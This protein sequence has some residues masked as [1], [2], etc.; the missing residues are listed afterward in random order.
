M[1]GQVNLGISVSNAAALHAIV[2]GRPNIAMMYLAGPPGPPG[3][4]NAVYPVLYDIGT[5]TISL[6]M[7]YFSGMSGNL[8]DEIYQTGSYLYGITTGASGYLIS[9]INASSAGVSSINGLSGVLN[10]G[11]A[12]NIFVTTAGQTIIVSGDTG[13]YANFATVDQLTQTGVALDNE[14]NA[15]SGF[16]TGVSGY[17]QNQINTLSGA[18]G[19]YSTGS[20]LYQLI[21][22]LSGQINSDLNSVSGGL[23]SEIDGLQTGLYQTGSDLYALTT[24]SSG[25]LLGLI[26]SI[27]AGV[28][29]VNNLSG[30]INITGAGNVS[31][32]QNGQNII[33]SGDT[34]A[35]ADF[36]TTAQL[37][38]TGA[39]LGNQINS[40]SGFVT[41]ISGSIQDQINALS[42]ATGLYATGS[43][44]YQLVTGLS[45]QVNSSIN[46]VSGGL[47]SEIGSLQT[48]LYQTGSNL[49]ALTTGSSG[50]LLSLISSSSAGVSSLNSLS[51]TI[52]VVGSGNVSVSTNGQIIVVSGDT[53]AYAD[54]ATVSQ[55]TQ[56]GINLQNSTNSLSGFVT[57]ISGSL[58]NQI[59]TLSG[60]TGLYSTGSSLYQL[61]TGLSGSVDEKF[62]QTGSVIIGQINSL[63]G[64][65][66]GVSGYLQSQINNL[67][68]ATGLYSTG[69]S[70][71]NLITG[72]SG[73]QNTNLSEASGVLHDQ[74]EQTGSYLYDTT[75]GASGYLLGLINASS[76]G[77]SSIN[78]LSG[79]LNIAGAG[80]VSVT[81]N[82]QTITVSGDT[83]AYINFATTSQLTQTGSTIDSKINSLS[84]F[85][86]GISG[87]LQDQINALSGATGLYST[88]SNLYQII[89]GLSGSVDNKF[90]ETG[91]ALGAQINSLSG[92]TTGISGYLQNQIASVSGRVIYIDGLSGIVSITGTGNVSVLINGQTIIVSGDTGAYTNFATTAQLAQ[93]GNTLDGKINSLSGFTTGVSGYLQIQI[94]ALSGATGLYSTGSNLY[95]LITGL[96]GSID[97]K[98]SQTGISLISQINSLSGFT[99]GISG[100]LQNQINVLTG[101]T[102][103]YSTGSNLY[104]LITGLSGSTDN[105]L[106]QTGAAVI[107]YANGIG[108]NL[109]GNLTQT[110]IIL[111]G[112]I[113]SLSG[114][115]GNVSGGLEIRI[116]QT[117][118]A[119]ITYAN[120]V[121]ANLSGNL[122]QT[123]TILNDRIVD[124]SGFTTGV[125]GYLQS[126][127]NTLTGN[128]GLFSTGSNLYNIITGLSGQV[129]VNLSGVS[130]ALQDQIN[131]VSTNLANT[132]S[133]LYNLVTGSSGY[134]IQLINASSAGVSSIN[135]ASGAV[136]IGGAGNVSVFTN[137]QSITVSGDTGAYNDF[138]TKTQ[139]TQTGIDLQNNINSLSGFVT[140]SSGYLKSTLSA[141]TVTGS[142][143]LNQANLSGIGGTLIFVSG[144][145]ILISGAG[146]AGNGLPAT[147]YQFFTTGIPAGVDNFYINYPSGMSTVPVVVPSIRIANDVVY[148]MA[149]KNVSK[150]GFYAYFTNTIT[151]TNEVSLDVHVFE[152]GAYFGGAGGSANIYSG[153]SDHGDGINLSGDLA[154]TGSLLSAVRITGSSIINNVNIYGLGGTVV[155]YSGE[156]VFVS[157][158]GSV[159]TGGSTGSV[160]I[161]N[162]VYTTGYQDIYDV[163]N[164]TSGV[165]VTGNNFADGQSPFLYYGDSGSATISQ[166]GGIFLNDAVGNLFSG[167]Y[168]QVGYGNRAYALNDT[169]YISETDAINPYIPPEKNIHLEVSSDSIYDSGL[170]PVKRWYSST[171]DVNINSIDA[172]FSLQTWS[173]STGY[174]LSFLGN[175]NTYN[176]DDPAILFQ[177][178]DSFYGSPTKEFLINTEGLTLTYSPEVRSKVS[179]KENQL[180]IFD[181]GIMDWTGKLDWAT[182]TLSGDWYTNTAST[183]DLSVVNY[184]RLT[185]VSGALKAQIGGNVNLS[186]YITTGQ[187]DLRYYPLSSNPSGY[188]TTGQ[189]GQF[190]PASNPQ[191]YATSG[192]LT[193]TGV[194]LISRIDSLS[195]YAAPAKADYLYRTGVQTITG[196]TTINGNL[197]VI[198]GQYQPYK[199]VGSNYS[200]L[201]TD[202]RIYCNNAGPITL[203]LPAAT[204]CSGLSL[205]IKLINVGNVVLTGT[206][207]SPYIAMIDGLPKY[208]IVGQY[209]S[210]EI[211]AFVDSS[212]SPATP[213]WYVW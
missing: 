43:N 20:N 18:T 207:E 31:I 40:L 50:Y 63:S 202:T 30:A 156:Y 59:N 126:Q 206:N 129:D 107:S 174:A 143:V 36:A 76:A 64:F 35:Y 153:S 29:S 61:I 155:F 57:G 169:S 113:D 52:N 196:S 1:T 13:S 211:Q 201:S 22:G 47:Q 158:G 192:N 203:T 197:T 183:D 175:S 146:Q 116:A 67:S 106:A 85:T 2:S 39:A 37:T 122:A 14:I 139:L 115:V 188:V 114:F 168:A 44:L 46:S 103:L 104:Q 108:T 120:G 186:G 70:L 58:Q 205:K 100:Y 83:G 24:G 55:L 109:S 19:L 54:F 93:T 125:S 82:G 87:Y 208:D 132:G 6:D 72:L 181:S 157:G 110:G 210:Y 209:T 62:A 25:Y 49:Y 123:G 21:T 95:Q 68:G 137:G 199:V 4:I 184:F 148:G 178:Y 191:Q 96:S 190:Y 177:T 38:Q 105:K 141:V 94:N 101:S 10:V 26:G 91:A 34:G 138:A 73:Q 56:T 154:T 189:T 117:G 79:A 80:N 145:Q 173:G 182:S 9:L 130:G 200:I 98:L 152:S 92:F 15:L 65:T 140:G 166:Y 75:T 66:T 180:K 135:S 12:G 128:T 42:G 45:G 121:G 53:G 74:I 5:Q 172:G 159:T 97:S 142:S 111:N 170:S 124:L 84:G 17:L 41:G 118:S 78:G 27:T 187:A 112:K 48:G 99:T 160:N 8:S 147:G 134:L 198:S 171:F 194:T 60:A 150:N 179:L 212:T 11:G 86:T 164:F 102:G 133:S 32:S 151:G 51:G 185:G 131:E 213:H 144:N 33:V 81:A 88:G 89:T 149:I 195:G 193:Q 162:V 163:K 90:A 77:V 3:V 165:L 23:Q 69:S 7:A 167:I 119:S 127:I 176:Y 16:T 136:N 71:Y 28:S 204:T 161:E